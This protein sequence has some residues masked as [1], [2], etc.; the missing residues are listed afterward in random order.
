M[1]RSFSVLADQLS[2]A[3]KHSGAKWAVYIYQSIDSWRLLADYRLSK[4]RQKEILKLLKDGKSSQWLDTVLNGEKVKTRAI[5]SKQKTWRCQ[6]IYAFPGKAVPGMLLAGADEMAPAAQTYF[7]MLALDLPHQ[8]PILLLNNTA[9]VPQFDAAIALSRSDFMQIALDN[10]LQVISAGQ[11]YITLERQGVFHVSVV[12][13]LPSEANG[14]EINDADKIIKELVQNASIL[15]RTTSVLEFEGA[16]KLSHW[17]YLPFV[18]QRQ[19]IGFAGFGRQTGFAPEE[20]TRASK[21]ARLL[22]PMIKRE[23]THNSIQQFIQ[24]LSLIDS[25]SS[26]AVA[27]ITPAVYAAAVSRLFSGAIK[28]DYVNIWILDQDSVT[29]HDLTKESGDELPLPV[30]GT[31]EGTVLK[32]QQPVRIDNFDS[33]SKYSS[34]NP[35]VQAKLAV[36]LRRHHQIIGVISLERQSLQAFSSYDETLIELLSVQLAASLERLRL[37]QVSNSSTNALSLI[38]EVQNTITR[39]SDSRTIAQKMAELLADKFGWD[40]VQVMLLAEG[41]NELVVEGAAG[42]NELELQPGGRYQSDRG[43]PGQV[44]TTNNYVWDK[45][46]GLGEAYSTIPGWIPG[47]LACIPISVQ[48]TPIGVINIEDQQKDSIAVQDIELLRL[49]ATQIA[50]SIRNARLYQEL[51]TRI[52]EQE[53]VEERLIRSAKLAAVGEMAAGVA[54]ELNN[55]LTTVTGFAELILDTMP[56][57]SPEYEDMSLVLQE[58][59]RARGVVRRLLDFSRQS[60]VLWMEVD[61]NEL[62]STVLALVHHL[63]L[64]SGVDVRV[65]FWNELPEI[66]ADRNQMQQVFLN[67]IHNAIQAMPGGGQLVLR[68][69]VN[70]RDEGPWLSIEVQDNGEGIKRE[71]LEKVFEPFYTTKPSGMGTGLGLSV[72]YGIV[73]EHGGYIDVVSQPG[74]GS[75]FTVWLPVHSPSNEPV[76]KADV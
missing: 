36:P 10:L 27:G 45:E 76:E 64:T 69:Q 56:E 40:V 6:K 44:L 18:Y 47:S 22:S 71:D 51:E 66:R 49:I 59:H 58:A 54:H 67:L 16:E 17:V 72:S 15:E 11:A 31:L 39:M 74:E 28:A 3:C 35:D 52:K 4:G 48:D 46:M 75:T 43:T 26:L 73:S 34:L 42:S 38:N 24:R 5:K 2:L 12:F 57:D 30:E 9:G 62:L 55:P 20:L 60:E 63:A 50:I 13:N 41:E 25:L 7:K 19:V 53:I 8:E 65:E 32:V 61:I 21:A 14:M 68:T 23:I 29:F 1:L 33:N 37:E 70:Q